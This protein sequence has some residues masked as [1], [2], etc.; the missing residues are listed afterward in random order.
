M[1]VTVPGE[2][3]HWEQEH[4]RDSAL[5]VWIAWQIQIVKFTHS[6]TQTEA[7]ASF[8]LQ[9]ITIKISQI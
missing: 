3:R 4:C 7:S 1:A 2:G 5:Q 9:L 8:I 6:D